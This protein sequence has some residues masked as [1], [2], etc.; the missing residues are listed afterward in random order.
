MKTIGV[1][2]AMNKEMA[3][4]KTII[5]VTETFE[6]Y[7]NTFFVESIITQKLFLQFQVLARLMRQ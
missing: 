4:L 2:V 5:N 7:N 6:I 3:K 1:I